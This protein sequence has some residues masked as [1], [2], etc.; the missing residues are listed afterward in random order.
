[1]VVCGDEIRIGTG[2]AIVAL[3]DPEEELAE[4]HLKAHA[5]LE[6]IQA[7]ARLTAPA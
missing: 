7:T 6:S 3:S 4:I 1:M 5:L 2:G